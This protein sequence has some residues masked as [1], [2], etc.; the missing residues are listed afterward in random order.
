MNIF[1]CNK[2]DGNKVDFVE[3]ESQVGDLNPGFEARFCSCTSETENISE[4]PDWDTAADVSYI[5]E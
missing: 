3:G 4:I 1:I 5:V 2:A